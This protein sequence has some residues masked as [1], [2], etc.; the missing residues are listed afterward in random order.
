MPVVNTWVNR[1]SFQC[2]VWKVIRWQWRS[3]VSKCYNDLIYYI[4]NVMYNYSR[5]LSF[6]LVSC[7]IFHHAYSDPAHIRRDSTCT[8]STF[9]QICPQYAPSLKEFPSLVSISATV[10]Q[11]HA[12]YVGNLKYHV[13]KQCEWVLEKLTMQCSTLMGNWIGQD[14]TDR[15]CC[16]NAVSCHYIILAYRFTITKYWKILIIPI[17]LSHGVGRGAGGIV[18]LSLEGH[19]PPSIFCVQ[20]LDM[21]MHISNL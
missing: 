5:Q 1:F 11:M 7:C 9:P 21:K 6:F 4:I 10:M 13:Q 14:Q 19:W 15:K 20:S 12:L 17:C 2:E 18:H 3:H 16:L 8:W